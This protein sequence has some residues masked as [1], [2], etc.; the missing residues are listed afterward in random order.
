MKHA[1][2]AA[3]LAGSVVALGA[4][5]PAFAAA[6]PTSPQMS[7][8]GGV[9]DVLSKTPSVTPVVDR[10]AGTAK[11]VKGGG[12]GQLLDGATGATK[13]LPLVGGLPLGK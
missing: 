13:K 10:V 8:N 9:T 5:A 6:P 1:K 11:K 4:A 12:T 2:T 3:I 7:L